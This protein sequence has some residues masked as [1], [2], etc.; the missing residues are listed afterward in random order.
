LTLDSLAFGSLLHE[1]LE[2]TVT[3]LETTRPG[4]FAGASPQ[5]IGK[6]I[7]IVKADVDSRWN[8]SRPI[9]PP[10]VWERKLAEAAELALVAL[11]YHDD[12]LHD[13]RSWA[14]IP[15]GGDPK[16]TALAEEMRLA[17]PWDPLSPVIIP[18]THI[19][20]G[21][22]IDRLDL[23]GDGS[24]ARVTDYKS[25]KL[26]GRPPQLKGG[27]ELQRCLYAYAVKA[28]VASRPQ[29]EAQ[30][31]YPRRDGRGLPLENPDG[32]LD[33]L[34]G[35]LIAANTSLAAGAAL[36]GPATEEAWYD[37]AFA[38]P[39]GAKESYLSAKLPLVAQVLAGIEPLW[40][41][42]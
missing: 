8:E 33:R 10:A 1:I 14:E 37:L 38:L 20:I 16:A 30:L 28:L 4:G 31:L 23:A 7:E 11:S 2:E 12:P 32:T 27:A 36:P 35:Y 34:T 9:P 41:E 29:V 15:F 17:L 6:V 40:G 19:R 25:G 26:H 21:G 42:L 5:E 22:S 24:R 18:G 13:E 39:G 3:R